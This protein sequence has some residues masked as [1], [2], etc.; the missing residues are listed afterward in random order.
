MSSDSL[1]LNNNEFLKEFTSIMNDFKNFRECDIPLCAAENVISDFS[2]IPLTKGLQ[3]RYILGGYLD[4]DINNNMI[5]SDKVLPLYQLVNKQCKKIFDSNYCDCRSLSGMNGMTNILLALT[6]KGDTVLLSSP[7]CGGHASLPNI[8]DRLGINIVYAPFDY[9]KYDY[10]YDEINSILKTQK[11]DLV[12]LAPSDLITIPNFSLIDY[13]EDVIYIFDA[14]QVMG[15]IAGKVVKNPLKCN[16][17]MIILGG[18]HKTIPG[19]T[20]AIILTNNETVAKKIDETINPDY[21]RNTQLH[22]VASLV[23]TFLEVETFGEAY[24]NDMISNSNY[25]GNKLES[26]G[27]NVAKISDKKYSNTHQLFIEMSPDEI[28]IFFEKCVKFNITLNKKKKPLYNGT[29][30]RLGVQEITRYG[31]DKSD[32]D[33]VAKILFLI[34]SKNSSE[35]EIIKLINEIKFKKDIKYTFK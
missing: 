14:S 11:I 30:I 9:S 6:Q 2:K 5:G 1:F 10:D 33:I 21:I 32:L 34:Y 35:Q 18:T 22:H 31:W 3:E 8:L 24:A 15:L 19:V 17:N 26:Y 12:L 7:D 25:L 16:R 27:F 29:G 23:Y 28:D 4:Y 13:Y 20:K